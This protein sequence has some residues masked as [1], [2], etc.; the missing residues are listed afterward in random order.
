MSEEDT[1]RDCRDARA[2]SE[3]GQCADRDPR[4]A[5]AMV[6]CIVNSPL[7]LYHSERLTDE[8]LYAQLESEALQSAMDYLVG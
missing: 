1:E 7:V 5:A 3:R 2:Y 4:L 6:L 8:R